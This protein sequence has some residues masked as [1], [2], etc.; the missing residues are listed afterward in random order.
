MINKLKTTIKLDKATYG[1]CELAFNRGFI[2]LINDEA[3]GRLK[4]DGGSS[5]EAIAYTTR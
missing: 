4:F 3:I 1:S 5:I 2:G